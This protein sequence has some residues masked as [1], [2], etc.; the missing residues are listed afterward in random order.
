MQSYANDIYD[1]HQKYG[2][3]QWV[4]FNIQN[5]ELMEK[6]LRFRLEMCQEELTET[7]VAVDNKDPEEVVD[8]LIDLIVFAL[9]TL[10]IFAVNSN[11]AWKKVFE[12]N[13]KKEVGIKEGRANPFLL[14]DLIKPE[15]WT[16]PDHQYN[17]GWL[18]HVLGGST[19]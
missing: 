11:T 15:G 3:H 7:M 4:K 10:D 9:G 8:G 5:R 17:H 1:M 12:A 18:P 14:P 16:A 2:V 19:D 13:M 6:Y